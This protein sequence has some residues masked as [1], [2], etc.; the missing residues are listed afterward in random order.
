MH[1]YLNFIYVLAVL[2]SCSDSKDN[3]ADIFDTAPIITLVTSTS[4]AGDNG[5]NDGI[6]TGVMNFYEKN[7][8]RLSLVHPGSLDEARTVLQSWI[9]ND[10]AERQLLILASSEYEQILRGDTLKLGGNKDILLFESDHV[11]NVSTFRIQRY[12]ASFLAGCIASPHAEATIIGAHPN[13]PIITDA[14]K[15][16]TDGYEKYNTAKVN[17]IYLADDYSGFAMPDSAYRLAGTLGNSFIYPLAGGSNNG[18]YKYSREEPFELMLVAGMDAD[19]SAYSNRI[20]FSVI[21]RTDKIIGNYLNMWLSTQ[22]MP[23]H[24]VYGLESGYIDILVSPLFNEMSYIWEDYYLNPDY[25][26]DA[27]DSYKEE[28]LKREKEYEVE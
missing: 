17:I 6:I 24:I 16:F 25:W 18:I 27:Y 22:E 9:N 14:I 2:S 11:P 19:C 4:G 5:Y 15:G 13:E 3:A 8:V 28:A 26:K 20:P 7:D 1:K 23:H 12:G 10:N 21:I